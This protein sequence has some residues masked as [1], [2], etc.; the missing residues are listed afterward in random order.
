M[1]GLLSLIRVFKNKTGKN[2]SCDHILQKTVERSSF[3]SVRLRFYH[4]ISREGVAP[5]PTP[6]CSSYRK[7]SL[8]VILD[9]GR[10]LYLLIGSLYIFYATLV[11]LVGW[12]CRIYR[13]HLCRGVKLRSYK[14]PGYNTKLSDA[15]AWV[16]ELWGMW[17]TSSLTLLPVLLWPGLV[18][19]DRVLYMG[20]IELLDIRTLC[21]QM[22]NAKLDF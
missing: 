19:S 13:L 17:S 18:A 21:K 1:R 5:S 15:E 20:Q 2:Y 16:A 9:Y 14:C 12:D 6:W 11:S 10:Q 7:G 8:R 4:S 22:T 3:K